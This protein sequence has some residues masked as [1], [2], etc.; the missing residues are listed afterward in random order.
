MSLSVRFSLL[1]DLCSFRIQ[2]TRIDSSILGEIG[3]LL[4][5]KWKEADADERAVRSR[6]SSF[7]FARH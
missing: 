3:K 5:A 1:F 6:F 2:L 7:I 4:G